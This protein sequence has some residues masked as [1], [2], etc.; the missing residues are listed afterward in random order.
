MFIPYQAY[1]KVCA[2]TLTPLVF[3]G[4]GFE[5]CFEGRYLGPFP[6]DTEPD[7]TDVMRSTAVEQQAIRFVPAEG[8]H[9]SQTCRRRFQGVDC[10]QCQLPTRNE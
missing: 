5:A 2:F 7:F 1:R 4:D 6:P 3:R 9:A 8:L 10:P